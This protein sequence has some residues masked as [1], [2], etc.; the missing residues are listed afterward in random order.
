MQRLIRN[1]KEDALRTLNSGTERLVLKAL[2]CGANAAEIL[3]AVG[4]GIDRAAQ[5]CPLFVETPTTNE[6]SPAV[7]L[8][9][10]G[11]NRNQSS[12]EARR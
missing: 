5:I 8:L 11:S 4:I 6:P 2:R 9:A 3:N 1:A 12:Q 10:M 7:S